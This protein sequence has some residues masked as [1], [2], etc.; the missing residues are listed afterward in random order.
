MPRTVDPSTIQP[1]VAVAPA[2]TAAV[3]RAVAEAYP[4]TGNVP[5]DGALVLRGTTPWI[6]V[7]AYGALGDG[8][9]D[10]SVAI[11]AAFDAASSNGGIVYFPS[12]EYYVTTPLTLTFGGLHTEILGSNASLT[13]D[14]AFAFSPLITF[15]LPVDT[16][17]TF[18]AS[19][20]GMTFSGGGDGIQSGLS[21]TAAGA[22][23]G[24]VWVRDCHFKNFEFALSDNNFDMLSLEVSGCLF[25]NL[26]GDHNSSGISI[27]CQNFGINIFRQI[28]I[29]DNHFVLQPADAGKYL[30]GTIITNFAGHLYF[31]RNTV[32]SRTNGAS[33]VSSACLSVTTLTGEDRYLTID[34]NQFFQQTVGKVLNL[35]GGLGETDLWAHFCHNTMKVAAAV[36]VLPTGLYHDGEFVVIQDNVDSRDH[37]SSWTQAGSAS[38]GAGDGQVT[39]TFDHA[40]P[41]AFYQVAL[42]PSADQNV[43]WSSKVAASFNINRNPNAGAITV[44]W[45]A[46]R[47]ATTDGSGTVT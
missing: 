27:A 16:D 44:D 12:G 25:Y 3:A 30:S 29:H 41:D 47:I 43:W 15:S 28:S 5:I 2:S 14:N 35:S 23:Y 10:D 7:K 37:Y 22:F 9:S 24:K 26:V 33:S 17:G 40:F 19:V 6:D 13:Y 32:D 38:M 21:F 42:T 34:G 45:I 39:V 46:R 11:Q 4:R 31:F 18:S 8:G 20:S 36:V 1:Y